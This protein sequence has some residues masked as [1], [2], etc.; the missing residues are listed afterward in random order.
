ME[1]NEARQE[2]ITRVME[3]IKQVLNEEQCEL[4]PFILISAGNL[5]K[6][7]INVVAKPLIVQTEPVGTVGEQVIT[8]GE[9]K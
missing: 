7:E 3:R 8:E 5:L 4:E 2:R 6:K 1:T 9:V